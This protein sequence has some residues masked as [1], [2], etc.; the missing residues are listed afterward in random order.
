MTRNAFKIFSWNCQGLQSKSK[1]LAQFLFINKPPICCLQETMLTGKKSFKFDGYNLVNINRGAGHPKK[2]GGGIATLIKQGVE[3]SFVSSS[4]ASDLLEHLTLSVE[5]NSRPVEITNIYIPPATKFDNDL[6]KNVIKSTPSIVLGDINAYHPFWQS[7]RSDLRGN[8][9]AS[10]LQQQNYIPLNNQ[11]PTHMSIRKG[12]ITTSIIDIICTNIQG[13]INSSTF[14]VMNNNFGSDHS[15]LSLYIG[16]DIKNRPIVNSGWNCKRADWTVF[17]NHLLPGMRIHEYDPSDTVQNSYNKIITN[18]TAAANKSIPIKTNKPTRP[19]G[20]TYWDL[21]IKKAIYERNKQRNKMLKNRTL[22]NVLEYKRLRAVAQRTIRQSACKSWRSYCSSFDNNTKIGTVWKIV[23]KMNGTKTDSGNYP[24]QIPGIDR[25][26]DLDKAEAF[27]KFLSDVH[28]Y[29]HPNSSTSSKQCLADCVNLDNEDKFPDMNDTITD[30]EI[31]TTIR[32]IRNK[33][34]GPGDDGISYAMLNHLPNLFTSTLTLLFNNIYSSSC[35]PLQWKTSTII[36]ALKPDKSSNELN[37]YRPISLTP[38]LSKIFERIIARRLSFV[39]ENNGLLSKSQSGFRKHRSTE[40]QIVYVREQA[41]RAIGTKQF[42]VGVFI[43]MTKAFD[44]VWHDAILVELQKMGFGGKFIKFV[45]NFLENRT[46]KVKI[47]STNSGE[48]EIKNGV[49]QGSCLSPLLFLVLINS[50]P[51][52]IIYSNPLLYA[53]DFTLLIIGK[54]LKMLQKKLQIDINNFQ[55]WCENHGLTASEEK[56]TVTIFTHKHHYLNI[57]LYINNKKLKIENH[58]RYLGVTFD[59]NLNFNKHIEIVENTCN[60]NI[61]LFKRLSGATWG[62]GK[63]QLSIIYKS[64]ILSKILYACSILSGIS[65]TNMNILKHIQYTFLKIITGA[66]NNTK[67]EYLEIDTS[68]LPIDLAIKQRTYQFIGRSLAFPNDITREILNDTWHQ[69]YKTT[70]DRNMLEIAN[71]Y[72]TVAMS[73]EIPHEMSQTNCTTQPY[74]LP[75]IADNIKKIA[76]ND[77]A[78][79]LILDE[80]QVRWDNSPDSIFKKIFTPTSNITYYPNFTIV[81]K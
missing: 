61:G 65:K 57:D 60:K 6:L 73:M 45:H 52:V 35:L 12:K 72:L 67:T 19:R 16:G 64:L 25:P 50:L 41:I 4:K 42:A 58:V 15:M 66:V 63:F 44:T 34:S 23:N 36:P 70:K 54:C 8:T 22:S 62:M 10:L 29:D 37:N 31:K 21:D 38:S 76:F 13:I 17:Q 51:G 55:D 1:E 47:N 75:D 79:K 28:N 69:Y 20:L 40:E 33:Y 81:E 49:P 77:I 71:P 78:T 48:Y 39:L 80:W 56:S 3:Y 68:T 27:A 43:D 18:V 59:K 11:Q 26:T 7:D 24:I 2:L 53:D 32:S 74:I 5:I 30:F 46:I 14:S 9:I